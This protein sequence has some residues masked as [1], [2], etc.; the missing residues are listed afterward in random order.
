MSQE[1]NNLTFRW[2][3]A[4]LDAIFVVVVVVV[5][6]FFFLFIKN[7]KHLQ[8]CKRLVNSQVAA[9]EFAPLWSKSKPKK[10]KSEFNLRHS[11]QHEIT[12]TLNSVIIHTI[13]TLRP[14]QNGRHFPDDIF[15]R[16]LLNEKVK[17]LLRISMK[18]VPGGPINNIPALIQIMAWRRTGDKPLPEPMMVSLLTHICVT[19]P[20]W[21]KVVYIY[22]RVCILRLYLR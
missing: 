10:A 21:V 19:R 17:T 22:T 18:F 20:Q 1:P 3:G 14:R 8:R 12:C 13:I 4:S 7:L 2:I 5:V 16:I 11:W 15:K 6:V 9:H